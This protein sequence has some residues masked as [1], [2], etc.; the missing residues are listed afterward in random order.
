MDEGACRSV[1]PF[2]RDIGLW[3][4]FPGGITPSGGLITEPRELT[5]TKT[6]LGICDRF[7]CLPSQALA[8]DAE[9]LRY[10][11]IESLAKPEMH[12]EGERGDGS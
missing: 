6:I 4:D 10:L 2:A 3:R 12:G 7:H 11:K 1:A 5:D 8:E 9:I